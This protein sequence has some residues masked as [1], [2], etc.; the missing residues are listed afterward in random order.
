MRALLSRPSAA[1]LQYHPI[2][3]ALLCQSAWVLR[4]LKMLLPFSQFALCLIR[5]RHTYKHTRACKYLLV[6]LPFYCV[7][8]AVCFCVCVV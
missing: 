2:S 8:L 4:M 5:L 7:C 6:N 3:L 1:A